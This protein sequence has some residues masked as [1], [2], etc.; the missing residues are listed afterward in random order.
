LAEI[1]TEDPPLRG[2]LFLI[3]IGML[4]GADPNNIAQG[5]DPAIAA[6]VCVSENRVM[7]MPGANC[8]VSTPADNY[9]PNPV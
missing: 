5:E 4:R 9:F 3:D 7:S 2:A 8:R 1:L 6:Q